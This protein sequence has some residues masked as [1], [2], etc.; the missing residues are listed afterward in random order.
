MHS[1][2]KQQGAILL[3]RSS[4]LQYACKQTARHFAQDPDRLRILCWTNKQVD[5]YNQQIRQ[6][7]YGKAAPR[8][9]VNERLIARDP[10]YAPDGKTCLVQTSTEFTVRE[11]HEDRYANYRAWRLVIELDDGSQKQIYALHEDDQSRFDQD[12]APLLSSAKRSPFLWRRYYQ[13]LET[14]ANVRP[15]F[16][17][18]VHN[19]QGSTFREVGIDGTDLSKRLTLDRKDSAADRRAKVKEYNRLWYV[20]ASRA[21]ERVLIC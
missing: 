7:R 21:Q 3:R 19:S 8:F 6:H 5:Y 17:L 16:A 2:D 4:L 1:A 13:H 10:I 20:S 11:T 12:A 14:F 18:T 15:C 9:V